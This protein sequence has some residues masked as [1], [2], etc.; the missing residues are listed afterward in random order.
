MNGIESKVFNEDCISGMN[1][2]P[3][4]YFDLAIVD[5]PYFSG[6]EKRAFYGAAISSCGAKRRDYKPLTESWKVP[7]QDFYKELCR[8]SKNQIIWGINYFPD[9]ENVPAGRIVWDK[10]NDASDFSNCEIA[11]CSFIKSVRIFRYMWNGMM[12]GKS[13]REGHIMQGNKKLNEKK[14]HPTQKPV[15]LYKWLLEKYAK[16]GQKILDTHLGSG[17]SRI[18]AYD[19]GFDFTG[20][21]LDESYFKAADERFEE[22]KKQ[23]SFKFHVET[24]IPLPKEI[25]EANLEYLM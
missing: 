21:E 3:D 19:M 14:I 15:A 8:V 16:S 13:L 7:G 1:S 4:K 23:E 6:P 20:F 9:F 10:V 11:S 22:H 25:G 12:Q 2:F 5:P 18:A 17:S 24:L